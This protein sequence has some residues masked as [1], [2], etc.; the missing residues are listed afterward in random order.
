MRRKWLESSLFRDRQ[1]N[2]EVCWSWCRLAGQRIIA[3]GGSPT[4]ASSS[5]A[6]RAN[7]PGWSWYPLRKPPGIVPATSALAVATTTRNS[8]LRSTPGKHRNARVRGRGVP[9]L[10]GGDRRCDSAWAGSSGGCWPTTASKRSK[11]LQP[12]NRI[13]KTT[14]L[15]AGG[16]VL[17][18]TGASVKYRSGLPKT[19]PYQCW[20]HTHT[21][22]V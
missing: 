6:A 13:T 16:V 2:R 1:S 12:G 7:L 15:A 19:A 14:D 22:A 20:H 10:G 18:K 11:G 5:T 9:L 21:H 17:R 4:S 3:G 8:S